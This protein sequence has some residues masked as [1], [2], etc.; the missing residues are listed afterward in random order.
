[1][2]LGGLSLEVSRLHVVMDSVCDNDATPADAVVVISVSTDGVDVENVGA[3]AGGEG[4][5]GRNKGSGGE[6]G[7]GDGA[8]TVVVV[9][10]VGVSG[11][12]G[13]AVTAAAAVIA[14]DVGIVGDAGGTG[15]DGRIV[16]VVTAAVCAAV[17]T[18]VAVVV[19]PVVVSSRNL[20]VEV[21]SQVSGHGVG[22][23]EVSVGRHI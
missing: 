12:V 10:E 4:T 7:S 11:S 8:G 13:C 14:L 18:A 21:Q 17:E 19:V 5:G 3:F 22:S 15:I 16:V 23:K 1:V 20:I 6:R 2:A 9:A